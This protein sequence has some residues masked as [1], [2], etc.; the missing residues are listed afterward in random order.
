MLADIAQPLFSN[1]V[2]DLAFYYR[3][4]ERVMAHYRLLLP[5]DRFMD[6]DYEKLVH[7]PASEIRSLIAF[8]GLPWDAACLAPEHNSR[9][10]LTASVWQARPPIYR[11]S[12]GRRRHYEALLRPFPADGK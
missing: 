8:C 4:Y 7:D 9:A 6:L 3:Q 5:T 10:V 11:S 12:I 1:A 2:A